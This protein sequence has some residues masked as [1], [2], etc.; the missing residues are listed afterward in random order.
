MEHVRKRED[1][2]EKGKWWRKVWGVPWWKERQGGEEGA[3]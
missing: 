3:V 1:T 2:Q